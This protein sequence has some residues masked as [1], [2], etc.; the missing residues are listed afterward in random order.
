MHD[1]TLYFA[2]FIAPDIFDC[3]FGLFHYEIDRY[4]HLDRKENTFVLKI[5]R[6]AAKTTLL[7]FYV[8]QQILWGNLHYVVWIGANAQKANESVEAIRDLSLMP[9]VRKMFGDVR[10]NSNKWSSDEYYHLSNTVKFGKQKHTYDGIIQ[11]LGANQPLQGSNI[12]NFRPDLIV[13]DDVEPPEGDRLSDD[14]VKKLIK[15]YDSTVTYA[16]KNLVST[17]KFVVGTNTR[18]NGFIGQISKRAG[19]FTVKIPVLATTPAMAKKYGVEVDQSIW[20]DRFP[21]WKMHEL[22]DDPEETDEFHEQM[23]LIDSPSGAAKINMSQ[24][25]YLDSLEE[26]PQDPLDSRLCFTLDMAFKITKDADKSGIVAALWNRGHYEYDL[27]GIEGKFGTYGTLDKLFEMINFWH[28]VFPQLDIKVG[29][30][31]YVWDVI[32]KEFRSRKEAFEKENPGT[33][34]F[35]EPLKPK[36]VAKVDRIKAKIPMVEAG[37]VYIYRPMCRQLIAK[38]AAFRGAKK[39]AG[40][41][42]EDA[43]AYQKDVGQ[44]MDMSVYDK[45]PVPYKRR[46]WDSKGVKP[47][48]GG[49]KEAPRRIGGIYI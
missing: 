17:R 18:E 26:I 11:S 49:G 35:L 10:A 42:L 30:E 21:T 37:R 27:E 45:P 39:R 32:E 13:L 5:F 19:T 6:G 24:I 33:H 15:W 31:A 40:D 43:W 3:P 14:M 36:H 29:I 47:I 8:L 4:F 48:I 2:Q 34:I 28:D 46:W 1:N 38:L 22:R 16:V 25:H 12:S 20:E 44:T 7:R 9:N 41:D 23:L